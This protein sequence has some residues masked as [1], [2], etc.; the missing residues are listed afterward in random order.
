MRKILP[1]FLLMALF[2]F[3]SPARMGGGRSFG[4]RGSRGVAPRSQPSSRYQPRS[5]N[6]RGTSPQAMPP[7]PSPSFGGGGFM[8]SLAGGLAGGLKLS[9][10][11]NQA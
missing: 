4:S 8:R 3:E 7:Q 10:I 9:A 2:A 1:V 6:Y 5:E 11:E